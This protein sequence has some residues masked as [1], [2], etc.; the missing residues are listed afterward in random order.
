M[1][2]LILVF[3]ILK[4]HFFKKI[5]IEN[6]IPIAVIAFDNKTGNKSYNYLQDAIP[7]LLITS[8]EQSPFFRVTTWERMYDLLKQ[9]GK[10][11]IPFIDKET[12]FELCHLEGVNVIITGSFTRAD[13]LFITD[14]KILDVTT[15]EIIKS[16]S[17]K[18][19]ALWWTAYYQ[20]W[21]GQFSQSISTINSFFSL[22]QQ[23]DHDSGRAIGELILGSIYYEYQDYETGRAI[24]NNAFKYY[25][26]WGFQPNV[27]NYNYIMALLDLERG[28][29]DSVKYRLERIQILIADINEKYPWNVELVKKQVHLLQAEVLLAE[30]RLDQAISKAEKN[31]PAQIYLVPTFD[32]VLDNMPFRQDILARAYLKV[33]EPDK[34]ITIYE[35]LTRFH[36]DSKDRRLIYPKYHYHL[37]KLY[38]Q[39]D[40]KEK[41]IAQYQKFL[42]IWKNA[43]KD[44]PELIDT[45]NRLKELL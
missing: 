12:G 18:G 43:D 10:S 25:M 19:E 3:L 22:A 39:T 17:S 21:P 23:L 15:K 6:P 40:Q 5:S 33:G 35:H 7:N 13:D 26:L 37:A 45:K 42:K 34:A 16:T 14:V 32:L 36:P 9:R 41:A 4:P 1:I 27:S 44:Q 11:D 20:Y 28:K 24:F 8:L 30:N 38:Q 2:G 29:V 31:V